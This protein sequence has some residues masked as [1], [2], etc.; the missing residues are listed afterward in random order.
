MVAMGKSARSVGE[1]ESECRELR[2]R[3]KLEEVQE[4]ACS[5]SI[6][7]VVA[8]LKRMARTASLEFAL[9]VGALIIHHF[10]AGDTTAWRARGPKNSSFRRLSQHPELP[11]SAGSLYRC[12][13][14]FE[15]CE[16]LDAPSRW[17]H[18]GVSHLR[19]VIGLPPQ[20]QE[21]LLVVAND[22][23]WTV[24]ALQQAM[25]G[26]KPSRLTF[27][28]RRAASPLTRGLNHL[29]RWFH[30]YHEL[31]EQVG[32]L[33]PEELDHTTRLLDEARHL[34][35]RLSLALL[36]QDGSRSRCEDSDCLE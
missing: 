25:A 18:L 7:L 2:N 14:L 23:R 27:G 9:Q 33:S 15:L 3:A 35:D 29:R 34:L 30:Q 5:D 26:E 28:G 11:L 20:T 1:R 4:R 16:R 31:V 10:Y 17:Q 19:L 6:E 13:A 32:S 8:Q 36:A 12:V 22:Q 21:R 24:Q